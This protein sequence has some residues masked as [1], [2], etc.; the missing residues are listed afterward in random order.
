LRALSAV[1][2]PAT[3]L[4][5]AEPGEV[6]IALTL[7][8]DHQIGDPLD[9]AL[10]LGVFEHSG[11]DAHVPKGRSRPLRSRIAALGA[12]PMEPSLTRPKRC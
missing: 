3:I 2:A 8:V 7:D 6:A 10:L 12:R 11:D 1:A 9:Q 5:P 4:G